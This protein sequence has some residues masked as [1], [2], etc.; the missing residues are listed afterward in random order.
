METIGVI[1]A[2]GRSARFGSP[3]WDAK[4]GGHSLLDRILSAQREVFDEVV[5]VGSNPEP[6][7]ALGLPLIADTTGAKGPLAGIHAALTYA[8]GRA[9][10]IGPCDAPFATSE[11]YR[12]LLQWADRHDN[13]HAI[14]PRSPGPRG[15]EP[16]FGWFSPKVLPALTDALNRYGGAVHRFI[17][18]LPDV[19]YLPPREI[20]RLAG[21]D[22]LF[23]NVNTP[24]DLARAEAL[25]LA[26]DRP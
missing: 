3:K 4:I 1:L 5:I 13:A 12:L 19:H 14:F 9:I 15:F 11:Y 2:G 23:M 16:L 18:T 17:D 7:R 25:F 21:G 24:A 26:P 6:F 8:A 20:D 22:L 10:A